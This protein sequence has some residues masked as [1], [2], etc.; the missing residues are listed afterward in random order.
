MMD[1][2]GTRN[3]ICSA[4]SAIFSERTESDIRERVEA[5]YGPQGRN[6]FYYKLD[7]LHHK[8]AAA[9]RR[10]AA[11]CKLCAT[12]SSWTDRWTTATTLNYD[13]EPLH[14]DQHV[15][16]KL[17]DLWFSISQNEWID[18][19]WDLTI[20]A[21]EAA[22]PDVDNFLNDVTFSLFPANSSFVDEIGIQTDHRSD[23]ND[24]KAPVSYDCSSTGDSRVTELA[25]WWYHQ[26]SERHKD[27]IP[28]QRARYHPKRLIDLR[29][30]LPKLIDC[31]Q[32][33]P[34][35][36]YAALSH[37]WGVVKFLT[38]S[39]D[40]M[41]HF[42]S[43]IDV[44]ELPQNF[45]DAITVCKRM[46][47][48]YLWIDSLCIIQSGNGS[49]EDWQ[50]HSSEMSSIYS[51]SD[52]TIAATCAA[53]ADD[54][55]FRPRQPRTVRPL[56]VLFQPPG[57]AVPSAYIVVQRPRFWD[58]SLYD[59][60]LFRRAWII[61]ERLL[62]SRILH[63]SESQMFWECR[64]RTACETFPQG[65]SGPALEAMA[66]DIDVMPFNIAAPPDSMTDDG[67][68]SRWSTIVT[69]YTRCA[70]THPDKDKLI[71]L[72]GIAKK[73]AES[74][75]DE[76]VVGFFRQQ[77]PSILLWTL[78]PALNVGQVPGRGDYYRAPSWSWA[79]IDGPIRMNSLDYTDEP[80]SFARVESIVVQL[81]DKQNP[82]GQVEH[83]ELILQGKPLRVGWP[84]DATLWVDP[85]YPRGLQC[86][87]ARVEDPLN[88]ESSF[89]M[90]VRKPLGD[91]NS[92]GVVFDGQKEFGH[93]QEGAVVMPILSWK[94]LDPRAE[95][96][97]LLEGLL[98]GRIGQGEK[99]A[100]TRLGK[101]EYPLTYFSSLL[102][103]CSEKEIRIV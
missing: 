43:G 93:D 72:A 82:F 23:E 13:E 62:S 97:H 51:N 73:V 45:Q 28:P 100:Y 75:L 56:R 48:R 33:P 12:F 31:S 69:E 66:T 37:C 79:S 60:P 98:L 84:S 59:Q 101:F 7:R 80:K 87:T 25:A 88:P 3:Y 92:Y 40:K 67:I 53:R 70:I 2:V 65:F 30:E 61:Q 77:F 20:L 63:L 15:V 71:A 9:L 99:K 46:K 95:E 6:V 86:S 52:L 44:Q 32:N 54:G 1:E 49:F 94:I 35:E 4:C 19:L 91:D 24:D 102:E 103:H 36:P 34:E 18:W 41:P 5:P 85:S 58:L 14:I 83:A 29:C 81:I 27:C 26:C 17:P 55:C 47:I 78:E 57:E 64:E 21:T 68:S 50:E 39:A 89:D 76:Y 8:D 10:A 16:D 90:V 74:C 11:S 42:R 22:R 96:P 38:L